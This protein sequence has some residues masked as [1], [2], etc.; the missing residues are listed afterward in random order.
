LYC[1][2]NDNILSLSDIDVID[3]LVWVPSL[4]LQHCEGD[5]DKDMDCAGDMICYQRDRGHIGGV[6]GCEVDNDAPP[7]LADFCIFPS[8]DPT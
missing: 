2:V 8:D 6:P 5:C 4:P 7:A 1:E 3:F